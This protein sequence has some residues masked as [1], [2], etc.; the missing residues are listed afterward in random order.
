[1]RRRA[2]AIVTTAVVLGSM[3]TLPATAADPVKVLTTKADEYNP[4]A[5]D[6]YL[7]WNV[8]NGSSNI[9]YAKAFGGSRMRVSPTGWHG[10]VGSIEDTS[11][12]YQQY[13]QKKGVS[14]IYRVDLVTKK[15]SKLPAAI[16]TERWEYG[17]SESGGIIAFAR[18]LP[19]SD[20]KL[21]V[22]DMGSRTS[23]TIATSSG[24]RVILE[25][26]QVSGNWL[27]YER[28][29]HDKDGRAIACD[30]WR[31]DIAGGS[32]TKIPNPNDRC[33]YGPSVDPAGTVYFA[34]GGFTCGTNQSIQ[35]YPVGGPVATLI[36]LTDGRRGFSTY[37]STYAV[38]NGDNT[39][40]L[41]YDPSR[42]KADGSYGSGDIFKVT[43]P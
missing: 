2:T 7:S 39:T 18:V 30:V 35:A 28:H 9:V 4:A 24:V 32:S 23:R 42:C 3:G 22:Y 21:I 41:Y 33:Q 5:S 17:P 31:Y 27:A 26:G 11:L 38:D 20:R 13:S 25:V 14:D 19:T 8:W 36:Q 1:M 15:R 10:W 16:N 37:F 43:T 6:T 29:V 34:R 12:T 40:D